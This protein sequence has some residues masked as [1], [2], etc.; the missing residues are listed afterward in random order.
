MRDGINRRTFVKAVAA[1]GLGAAAGCHHLRP[2]TRPTT[3]PLA[4]TRPAPLDP[5][6]RFAIVGLGVR[7]E[8]YQGA[9]QKEYKDYAELVGICDTNPGRLEL[10]RCKSRCAGLTPPTAYAPVDFE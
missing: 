8:M 7:S 6:R 5:K 1:G 3:Q 10:S 4:A 9:I 2:S